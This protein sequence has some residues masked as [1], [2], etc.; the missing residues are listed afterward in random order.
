MLENAL[1]KAESTIRKKL[2]VLDK[3]VAKECRRWPPN[4]DSEARLTSMRE[5]LRWVLCVGKYAKGH[6]L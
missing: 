5:A 3:L 6:T 4:S 1:M 2:Q